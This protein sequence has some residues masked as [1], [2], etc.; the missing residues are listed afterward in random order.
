MRLLISPDP[1][2]IEYSPEH[3]EQPPIKKGVVGE[4]NVVLP[5]GQYHVKIL[6]KD[7]RTLAYVLMSEE[8][9]EP[10]EQE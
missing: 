10:A 7:S 8:F 6:D 3:D 4:I 2:Y 5:N 1:E 9:L